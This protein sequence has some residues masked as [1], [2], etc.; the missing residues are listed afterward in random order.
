LQRINISLATVSSLFAILSVFTDDL[1]DDVPVKNPEPEQES[2]SVFPGLK[3]DSVHVLPRSHSSENTPTTS[4]FFDTS[5]IPASKET[6]DILESK[7]SSD[8]TEKQIEEPEM[9]IPIADPLDTPLAGSP[10]KA[11]IGDDKKDTPPPI[12]PSK[13]KRTVHPDIVARAFIDTTLVVIPA[14]AFKKLVENFPHAG[15][16]RED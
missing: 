8:I 10:V 16:Y 3:R 7:D 9:T 12:S 13:K 11:M 4:S 1:D 5:D 2:Q 14:E 15:I 6:N